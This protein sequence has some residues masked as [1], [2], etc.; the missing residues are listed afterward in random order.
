MAGNKAMKKIMA[1]RQKQQRHNIIIQTFT[2]SRILRKQESWRRTEKY[3][4]TVNYA[5]LLRKVLYMTGAF[6]L[7]KASLTFIGC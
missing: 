3:S 5:K 7:F 4:S 2:A 6:R 1:K